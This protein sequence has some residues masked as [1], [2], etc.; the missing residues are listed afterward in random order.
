MINTDMTKAVRKWDSFFKRH[1]GFCPF[2]GFEPWVKVLDCRH[3]QIREI[4]GGIRHEAKVSIDSAVKPLSTSKCVK[5]HKA[6][7]SINQDLLYEMKVSDLRY[8]TVKF[9]DHQ[10]MKWT[11]LISSQARSLG[12]ML[13]DQDHKQIATIMSELGNAWK[14]CKTHNLDVNVNITTSPQ[15]FFLLGHFGIDNDSC[16]RQRGCNN[17]HKYVLGA[18]P[19]SFVILVSKDNINLAR[20]FGF[21][22]GDLYRLSNIYYSMAED[23]ITESDLIAILSTFFTQLTGSKAEVCTD[24]YIDVP[25]VYIND[26]GQW[27]VHTRE[28]EE[29]DLDGFILSDKPNGFCEYGITKSLPCKICDRYLDPDYTTLEVSMDNISVVCKDCTDKK[30]EEAYYAGF[31]HSNN[32]DS[33]ENLEEVPF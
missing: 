29:P 15:A 21:L 24:A 8:R 22:D 14:N 23:S 13:S 16:F 4:L 26:Y 5:F 1:G 25:T 20:L 19:N 31:A 7:S 9:H 10:S 28:L 30:A 33:N 2:M 27:I 18:M 12:T 3:Q 6:L 11:R 32:I 17:S